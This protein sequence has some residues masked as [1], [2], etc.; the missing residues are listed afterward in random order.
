[1]IP[2]TWARKRAS[3]RYEGKASTFAETARSDHILTHTAI[4]VMRKYKYA[5]HKSSG[6]SPKSARRWGL[7]IR[8]LGKPRYRRQNSAADL[9]MFSLAPF[10][11]HGGYTLSKICVA[12]NTG[13][14]VPCYGD[15]ACSAHP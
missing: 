11:V 1:M 15:V 9:C 5:L 3:V 7:L 13:I 6:E 8:R 2:G 4:T 14:I 10:T 12:V